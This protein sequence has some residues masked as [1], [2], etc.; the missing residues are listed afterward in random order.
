M[1]P[2]TSSKLITGM[3]RILLLGICI[4]LPA[5]WAGSIRSD[6]HG[7]IRAWDFGVVYYG[8]RCAVQRLD[9]YDPQN[10][11][12]EFKADGGRFPSKTPA[13]AWAKL[14]VTAII[15]PPT[16]LLLAAPFAELPWRQARTI[17]LFLISALLVLAAFLMW[18][19]AVEAPV[20]AGCMA[21]FILLNCVMLEVSGN[22]VGVVAPFCVITAWCFLKQRYA[23]LGV[24]MLAAALLFKPHDAGFVW[25]YFLL[26]GG[27]MR[28]R[29]LQSLAIAAAVGICAAIWIAPIAPHWIGEL[30][31]NL[32]ALSVHGGPVDPG[33]MGASSRS[34]SPILGLQ[35]V[36]SIFKDDPRFYNP[37]SYVIGGGLILAWAIA[38]VRKRSSRQ[39]ALLALAAVSIL[40]MLPVYHRADDAKLVLLAIPACAM[41]WAGGGARRWLALA[42]ISAA[43]FV[44]SAVPIIFEAA[45]VAKLPLAPSTLRGKLALLA[46]QPASLVLLAAGCFYLW[47]YIGY[48][49]SAQ[50]KDLQE[51]A[52]EIIA[53]GAG[54]AHG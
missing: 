25:L 8:A 49:P 18:D 1:P 16:A 10:V 4:A 13:D 14:I 41:L 22:P 42:L 20:I 17:W 15:Y 12:Q 19:L 29:A 46:L 30:R 43:L 40:T 39:E 21:C 11:L 34:F 45:A 36:F 3:T 28:R 23:A 31:A 54:P 37:A 26:A 33:P 44:T 32:A 24:V 51:S 6:A 5:M 50:D 47:I 2:R 27:S 35:S 52:T 48:K 9:P 53:A 7:A 38:A